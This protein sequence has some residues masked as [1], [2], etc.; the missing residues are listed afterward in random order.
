MVSEGRN[1]ETT[2][3]IVTA[4]K[5]K[6]CQKKQKYFTTNIDWV[7]STLVEIYKLKGEDEKK[8]DKIRKIMFPTSQSDSGAVGLYPIR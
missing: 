2:S 3:G 4:L 5:G 1:I 6:H 8:K 7:T